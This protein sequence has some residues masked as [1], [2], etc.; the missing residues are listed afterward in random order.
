VGLQPP[1]M[2]AA[3]ASAVAGEASELLATLWVAAVLTGKGLQ[4]FV[5][6]FEQSQLLL[7]L[8]LLSEVLGLPED[9]PT[10]TSDRAAASAASAE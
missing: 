10:P 1:P 5:E 2:G 3:V 8:E 4:A 6:K 9:P 7:R